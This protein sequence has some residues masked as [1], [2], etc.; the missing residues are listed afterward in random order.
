MNSAKVEEGCPKDFWLIFIK[1]SSKICPKIQKKNR[2]QVPKVWQILLS[3]QIFAKTSTK[4]AESL[5]SAK[6]SAKKNDK[7]QSFKN[8]FG[9]ISPK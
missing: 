9:K 6:L 4:N 8:F 7:S 5:T 3:F 2:N 1:F